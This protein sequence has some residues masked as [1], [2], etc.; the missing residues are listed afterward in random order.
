MARDLEEL[1]SALSR[2]AEEE[3]RQAKVFRLGPADESREPEPTG[4]LVIIG[5]TEG[6]RFTEVRGLEGELPPNV[7][8]EDDVVLASSQRKPDEW[9]SMEGPNGDA[10]RLFSLLNPSVL[11]DNLTEAEF[12]EDAEG[13]SVVQGRMDLTSIHG[14]PEGF[15]KWL[16]D[17]AFQREVELRLD[18]QNRPIETTQ[19]DIFPR[20]SDRIVTRF[21]G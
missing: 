7:R 20:R 4:A 2:F 11:A 15:L 21:E 8:I 9:Q 1:R 12:I 17:D 19:P 13:A 18:E 16:G 14:L 3:T 10:L 5:Q 6:R